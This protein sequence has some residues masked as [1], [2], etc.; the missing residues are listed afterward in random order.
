M[1]SDNDP[2][3]SSNA[4]LLTRVDS[5][6]LGGRLRAARLA[7]GLTQS[8][9][10]AGIVATSFVS[11]VESGRRRPHLDVLTALVE[12][13]GAS[14][15][16][17]LSGMTRDRQDAVQS[18]LDLAELSLSSEDP[19]M[20]LG[21]ADAVLDDLVGM[22]APEL[23]ENALRLR[24]S[25][26]EAAGD[27]DGAVTDLETL[28]AESVSDV[29]WVRD[30]IS[31]SRCLR[32]SGRLDEAIAVAE[33]RQA[34]VERL[35]LSATTEAVQLTITTAGAYI[36]RGDLGHGLRTCKRALADAVRYR[37]PVAQAAALWNASAVFE[38]RGQT[39]EAL[40]MALQA[41]ELF[42]GSG[43][44]RNLGRLRNHVANIQLSLQPPD[45]AGAIEMLRLARKELDWSTAGALDAAR[46][47]LTTATALELLGQYEEAT[48]ELEAS[49]SLSPPNAVELLASQAAM[50]GRLAAAWGD[51]DLARRHYQDG[52]A[53]LTGSGADT[54]AAKLWYE[55][56][57]ILHRLDEPE[58]AADAFRRA[59]V[60]QGL[61]IGS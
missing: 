55:L 61:Q 44:T 4:A 60:S 13:A 50:R 2:V 27:L 35:G 54:D 46:H 17:V 19:S 59:G 12:R 26:R 18:T 7:A 41:L 16:L 1:N 20:A 53:M 32:E 31:L 52:V 21:V 25:A 42:E 22:N 8:Q 14:L 24:A 3:P 34:Q 30:L 33:S 39:E 47:R 36:Q 45:A 9:L 40:T 29:R 56:G 58:L 5:A 51:L 11:L 10:A 15:E 37:L 48:T 28:T 38:A 6:A 43:D 23:F 49:V 57:R